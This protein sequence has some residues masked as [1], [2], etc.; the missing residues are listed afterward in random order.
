MKNFS[1]GFLFVAGLALGGL[2]FGGGAF[3]KG[4]KGLWVGEDGLAKMKV[5]VCGGGTLCARIVWLRDP[6]DANGRPLIDDNNGDARLRTR[7]IIG[8]PVAYNMKPTAANKWQGVVYDPKRGG[9][10]Y[11]GYLNLLSDG[12][13]KVTGC[14]GFI[15]ESE[16]WRP[17]K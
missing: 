13:M 6:K 3:A 15:C 10:T 1:R 9:S 5:A 4:A 8:L 12:R 14:L 7:P 2:V 16:F 17:A 11:T